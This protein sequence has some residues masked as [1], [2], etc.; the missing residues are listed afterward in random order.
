MV[1]QK[2]LKQPQIPVTLPTYDE[3]IGKNGVEPS[4]Y[5]EKILSCLKP[6]ELNVLTIHAE[7]EGIICSTMF[8][9]FIEKA[10]KRKVAMKPLGE[11]LK[12]NPVKET[13]SI[14]LKP[15]SGRHG[16]AAIQS[17]IQTIMEKN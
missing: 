14:I 9:E 16:R 3:I 17:D 12:N 2:Q 15:I 1:N 8:Q 11:L 13:S 4:N 7:V 6:D 10:K 5:N